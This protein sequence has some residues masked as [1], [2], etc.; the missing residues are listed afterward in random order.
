MRAAPVLVGGSSVGC[1]DFYHSSSLPLSSSIG[2]KDKEPT[3]PKKSTKKK[4]S[5]KETDDEE[6][7]R[8]PPEEETSESELDIAEP[9]KRKATSKTSRSSRNVITPSGKETTLSER[10]NLGSDDA[11]SDED[12]AASQGSGPDLAPLPGT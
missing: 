7:Q 1:S 10:D 5:I 8:P 2:R 12:D 3:R 4:A 11:D 6:P 9:K